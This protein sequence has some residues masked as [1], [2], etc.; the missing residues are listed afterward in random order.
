MMIGHSCT[1][2]SLNRR[3]LTSKALRCCKSFQRA[4]ATKVMV[5]INSIYSVPYKEFPNSL[6]IERRSQVSESR[7]E[8]YL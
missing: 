2:G 4:R 3:K 6:A 5:S 1:A 7:L 8:R